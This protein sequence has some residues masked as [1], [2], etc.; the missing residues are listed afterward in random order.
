MP[1]D[2]CFPGHALHRELAK[3]ERG[4]IYSDLPFK[5]SHCYMVHKRALPRVVDYLEKTIFRPLGHPDGGKMY[6]DGAF[7][8][9]RTLNPDIQTLI[10]NPVLSVQRG[11]TSSLGGGRWYDHGAISRSAISWARTARDGLWRHTGFQWYG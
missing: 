4:L 8:L 6:I 10:S 9:Y 2:F 3:L 5:C 11:S 7:S 1:W